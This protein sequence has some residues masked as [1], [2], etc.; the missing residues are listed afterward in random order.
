MVA[1]NTTS[2][3]FGPNYQVVWFKRDLRVQ[4][5]AALAGAVAVGPV[6]PIYIVE[7]GLWAQPDMSLRHYQFLRG[8]ILSL[9]RA[10][11]TLGLRLVVR[12]GE[13]ENVLAELHK[14]FPFTA[15]W[16]HQET[17][18]HW[19]LMRNQRV[20]QWCNSQQIVWREPPQNAVVRGAGNGEAW[21][22][23]WQR[24][25]NTV[26]LPVP[27]RDQIQP[28]PPEVSS[29][30]SAPL[31]SPLAL[32]LALGDPC[33]LQPS[34]RYAGIEMLNDFL[35]YRG[36]FYLAHLP[37]PLSA[38]ATCS[39]LSVYLAFGVMSIREVVQQVKQ[40]LSLV[41]QNETLLFEDRQAWIKSLRA[42]L[43]R[44]RW[45]C[46]FIQR[47]DDT[48]A[49][50]LGNLHRG[51]NDLRLAPGDLADERLQAWQ[52]G[53]TG[54][55]LIDASMRALQS[56]GWINFKMRALLIGFASHHLWLSW[57]QP[58]SHLARLFTDYEPGIHY[59]QIQ[60]HAGTTGTNALRIQNPLALSEQLDPE[61]IFIRKWVP[62]LSQLPLQYI[63][64]PWLCTTLAP[65]YPSPVVTESRARKYA[66]TQLK[67][68]RETPEYSTEKARV[69]AEHN[70]FGLRKF[71]TKSGP[72]AP[73]DLE[74]P[75]QLELPF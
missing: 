19:S 13:A 47:L 71:D 20:S 21:A 16:S 38:Q 37:S 57:R 69:L 26:T 41:R 8:C 72:S 50:E 25:M 60:M 36:Q 51:Y 75:T 54:Y 61:G 33:Q 59:N 74:D 11:E 42:H 3:M 56:T 34:G 15:L 18:N 55:P 45:H 70:R 67:L 35:N 66:Y 24:F 63:H 10:L 29:M 30:Q 12:V 65:D 27:E 68:V 14:R 39:R 62:E 64:R 6:V 32:G 48:P 2:P 7:P 5:H 43:H 40:R 46:Q 1:A 4:D 17:W 73:G 52:S 28:L 53:T 31:P 49:L 58:A 44:L 23:H 9:N 22:R